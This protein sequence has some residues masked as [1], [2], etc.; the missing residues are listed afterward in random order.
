MKCSRRN[1]GNGAGNKETTKDGIDISLIGPSL[2][3][4]VI[5][6]ARLSN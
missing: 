2:L 5:R 3:P 6:N 4:S 1:S